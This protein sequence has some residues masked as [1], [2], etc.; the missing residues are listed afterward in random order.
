MMWGPG[1]LPRSCTHLGSPAE[2]SDLCEGQILLLKL[3]VWTGCPEHPHG[4]LHPFT[5]RL[6]VTWHKQGQVS[7]SRAQTPHCLHYRPVSSVVTSATWVAQ[8]CLLCGLE[9]NK[10]HFLGLLS[11][12]FSFERP[13]LCP[14]CLLCFVCQTYLLL[15]LNDEPDRDPVLRGSGGLERIAWV[16][17]NNDSCLKPLVG[18]SCTEEAQVLM[19]WPLG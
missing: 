6:W 9:T 8:L 1:L 19:F 15:A 17:S 14:V 3:S 2:W 4:T 13:G 5:R 12:D 11:T 18:I 16:A 7:D 10:V